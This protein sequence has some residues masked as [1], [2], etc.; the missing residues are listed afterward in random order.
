[1]PKN[2]FFK[3]NK[4]YFSKV[5]AI[6]LIFTLINGQALEKY[7]HTVGIAHSLSWN[8]GDCILRVSRRNDY[9]VY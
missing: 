2:G 1:M 5:K 9:P 8:L 7:C 3:H 6:F 4:F